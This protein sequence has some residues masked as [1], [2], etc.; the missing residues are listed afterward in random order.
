VEAG[1]PR[2]LAEK[3]VLHMLGGTAHLLFEEGLSLEEI[4][5]RIAVP[6]G[7]TE[8]GLNLLADQLDGVFRRLFQ[9]THAKY[10]EDVAK[11]EALRFSRP[12]H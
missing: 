6:G 8:Q 5:R 1:L 3:L 4:Q 11:I 9:T 7:I 2:P 12:P 10:A